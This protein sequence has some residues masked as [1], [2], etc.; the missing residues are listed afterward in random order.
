MKIAAKYSHLNGLEWLQ[1][2]HPDL[3]FEI[4]E[5][6]QSVDAYA[7]KTKISK[8]KT[9]R[10]KK[11]FAPKEMNNRFKQELQSRGWHNPERYDFL[12]T[13]DAVLTA[14]M[15]DERMSLEQ[16]KTFLAAKNKDYHSGFTEADF[17]KDRVS[18]EV[19]FGKYSFVQYDMFVKHA[20]DYMHNRIDL[21]IEIVP[22]KSLEK[23]MSSGPSNYERNLHEILR[24]GRIFPPVPL[25]LI[26]IAP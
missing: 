13:E 10:G 3:W 25:V 6:I 7:C 1:H 20:A 17:F 14:K 19:Q 26:G 21:G 4:D 22:M 9:M 11:L 24:Q 2:H 23:E 8:E 18:I 15:I 16:Q 12:L 5:S